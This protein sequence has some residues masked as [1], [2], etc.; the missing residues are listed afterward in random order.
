MNDKGQSQHSTHDIGG[1][2]F[3]TRAPRD[4]RAKG[5]CPPGLRSLSLKLILAFLLVGLTGAIIVSVFVGRYTRAAFGQFVF[6]QSRDPLVAVLTEFYQ[7]NESWQDVEMVIKSRIDDIWGK[8]SKDTFPE[9]LI[10]T[11]ANGVIL[12][13]W[14]PKA[15]GKQLSERELKLGV[16]IKAED[17]VVGWLLYNDIVGPWA[18]GTIAWGFFKDVQAA[19]WF[20]AGGATAAALL[21]GVLLARAISRPVRELTAAT[22]AVAEGELGRQV[23]V[24]S[25]DDLGELALS[26]NRMSADLARSNRLRRQMTADIAHDL[27]TPLSILL[28]YTEALDDGKLPGTPEMYGAMHSQARHLQRLIE[29]LRTLSLADAGELPMTKVQIAPQT[30]L[31]RTAAAYRGRAE[32]CEIAL[33]IG[34]AP[35]LPLL[36]VDPDRMGQ[37]LGNL[38]DNALRYTDPGGQITLAAGS[39]GESVQLSVQDSGAGIPPEDLPYVF[40]RF[41]RGDPSRQAQDGASGLGL[42]IAQSLVQ[43]HG[44]SISVEST[45]GQGASFTISIPATP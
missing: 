29:D 37:V 43:A 34:A 24:R 12:M 27:R 25:K 17:T 15:I 9:W 19:I 35:D 8:A 41:Y 4:D 28:G 21:L 39:A 11:D 42:A 10:L 16:P 44:G 22:R 38:M 18:P 7:T 26:F 30:L 23:T 36:N 2:R 45:V 40:E 20:S 31:E 32:Q 13:S 3:V 33:Q 1:D 5:L 6:D 14:G